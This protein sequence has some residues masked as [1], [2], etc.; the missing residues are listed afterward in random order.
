MKIK[1][2]KEFCFSASVMSFFVDVVILVLDV[3]NLDDG[4]G[5]DDPE[6]DDNRGC[7]GDRDCLVFRRDL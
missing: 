1:I 6:R 5:D 4:D 2:K 7:Y 3:G